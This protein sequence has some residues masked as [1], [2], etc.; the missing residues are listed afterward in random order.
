MLVDLLNEVSERTLHSTNVGLA[1]LYER[2]LKT[3]SERLARLLA[4]QGIAPFPRKGF[5]Q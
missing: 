1:R 3:G 4:Q 2:W 5:V